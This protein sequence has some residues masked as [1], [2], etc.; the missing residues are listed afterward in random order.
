MCDISSL[1]PLH[2]KNFPHFWKFT[3]KVGLYAIKNNDDVQ[4]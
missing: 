4:K 1:Q 3:S 2:F